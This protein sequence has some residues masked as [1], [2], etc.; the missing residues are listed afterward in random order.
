[1]SLIICPTDFSDTALN[2]NIYAALLARDINSKMLLVHVMHVPA[3]DVNSAANVLDTLMETQRIATKTKLEEECE[4]IKEITGVDVTYKS[5]FGL[6]VDIIIDVAE[7][8]N[9][10]MIVMGTNGASNVF[11]QLLGTVSYGVVK[12]SHVPVLVVPKGSKFNGIKHIAFAND[13]KEKLTSQME[14]IY[15]LTHHKASKID[16]ISVEAGKESNYYEEE[17]VC[18]EGGVKEVCI[19]ADD[20]ENGIIK[21]I[22]EHNVEVVAVKRHHRSFFENLFHHSTTKEVLN[23]SAIPV[24]IFN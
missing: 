18:D 5:D 17:C 10:T 12:R 4:K 21:Y 24:L 1:M 14:F 22:E 15:N 6:A 7:T 20:V 3:I 19:W 11:D 8:N 16:I 23:K 13:H 2:A 9:A